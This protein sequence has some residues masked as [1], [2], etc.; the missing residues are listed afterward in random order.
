MSDFTYTVEEY[1]NIENHTELKHEYFRGDIRAMSGGT[2]EHA[3]IVGAVIG[4]LA[5]QLREGPC[6][7]YSSELR[8]RIRDVITYPD[9]SVV[10]G[11]AR[12]DTEDRFA[13]LNP[14]LIVEVTS[15]STAKYDRGAKWGA[16]Q[17]IPSLREFVL[18]SHR[19]QVVE[20]FRRN[21]D[22]DWMDP[23][24]YG[25]GQ[26]AKLESVDCQLDVDKL[27]ENRNASRPKP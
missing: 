26:R 11:E 12:S 6:V 25:P 14:L 22:G 1:V 4:E 17:R 19:K 24:V 9:A 10:C 7:A 21:A 27:Y 23:T 8:V 20:V 18:V 3:R 16:Y 13:V 5:G 2:I 15:P